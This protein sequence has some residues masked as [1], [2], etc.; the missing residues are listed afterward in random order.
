[1]RLGQG[2]WSARIWEKG[3]DTYLFVLVVVGGLVG[4]ELVHARV[5]FGAEVT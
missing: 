1:M 4:F 2:E 5:A 3:R